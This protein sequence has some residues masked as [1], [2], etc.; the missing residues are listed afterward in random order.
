MHGANRLSGNAITEAL[1][2]GRI[3]AEA[4]SKLERKQDQSNRLQS[5]A[6]EE[7]KRLVQLW[8]PREV[9][10]DEASMLSVKKELQKLMWEG[11]GPLRTEE[12]LHHAL[13]Q[14]REL[15]GRVEQIALSKQN[16]YALTLVEKIELVHMIKLSESIIIGA[17]ARRETRG[18][19][20]RLDY[21][22]TNETAVS[23]KFQL[24]TN[25]QWTMKE[26]PLPDTQQQSEGGH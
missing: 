8:H 24:D 1:V 18:A 19:H 9:D 16:Y 26:I 3:A 12:S 2:T 20:V 11:A 7:F 14:L 21:N 15:G 17:L 23:T 13:E 25:R 22:Q 5:E 10:K 6:E 4:A